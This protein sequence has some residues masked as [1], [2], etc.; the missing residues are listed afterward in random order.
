MP[1]RFIYDNKRLV[2]TLSMG[3]DTAVSGNSAVVSNLNGNTYN[4]TDKM[5]VSSWVRYT[6]TPPN[7]GMAIFSNSNT[8]VL[9][10]TDGWMIDTA[11]VTPRFQFAIFNGTR[12]DASSTASIPINT[13]FHVVGTYDGA[14]V[15]IWVNGVIGGTTVATTGNISVNAAARLSI[16]RIGASTGGLTA[17]NLFIDELTLWNIGMNQNEV[18]ALY[19]SARPTNPIIHSRASNLQV[20]YRM[21]DGDVS[22][23]IRNR[24]PGGLPATAVLAGA[25]LP[26]F[27]P[28][29]PWRG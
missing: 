20:W 18:R 1:S 29:V 24:A 9:A 5:T 27:R 23:N 4:I 22:P 8:T 17:T 11:Q 28:N 12:R 13:W 21:G 14:T 10:I 7:T 15:A 25:P 2:N 19:N 3:V 26:T 6:K 16:G